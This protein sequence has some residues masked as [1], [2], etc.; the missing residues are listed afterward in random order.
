VFGTFLIEN[1]ISVNG[2]FETTKKTSFCHCFENVFLNKT[3]ALHISKFL[4][5]LS[6]QTENFFDFDN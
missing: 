1:L 5:E 4:I 2:S 6:R 3:D